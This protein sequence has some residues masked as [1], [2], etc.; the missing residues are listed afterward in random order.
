MKKL[1][2]FLLLAALVTLGSCVMESE[3][4]PGPGPEPGEKL[5]NAK[6]TLLVPGDFSDLRTRTL[7]EAQESAVEDAYV[8]IFDK[9]GSTGVLQQIV[10][11]EGITSTAN[12][13]DGV[14][15]EATFTAS[16]PRG[17]Y[18]FV[19]VANVKALMERDF[20]ASLDTRIG[21]TYNE[22]WNVGKRLVNNLTGKMFASGGAIP[23][24]GEKEITVGTVVNIEPISLYRSVARVDVGVG[25]WNGTGKTWSGNDASGKRIPFKITEIYVVRPH[26]RSMV[27]PS[28]S[29]FENGRP[30]I[31]NSARF[32]VEQSKELFK[33]SDSP[34]ITS[35]TASSYSTR[36]IYVPE[37]NTAYDH[38]NSMALVIGG[39]YNNSGTTSYYR[40]DFAIDDERIDVVRNNLY[41]FDISGVS[42]R[43]FN[44][45]ESAYEA[46][47]SNMEATL[48]EWDESPI[49]HI[50]RKGDKYLGLSHVKVEF[51]PAG[52]EELTMR[53]ITN[54][55]KF[56]LVWDG[57]DRYL[58][59]NN[60]TGFHP[61]KQ[62]GGD[63]SYV[64]RKSATPGEWLIEMTTATNNFGPGRS[65]TLHEWTVDGNDGDLTMYF[66]VIQRWTSDDPRDNAISVESSSGG[67]AIADHDTAPQ[68][69]SIKVQA[70][71]AVG[72][73]FVGWELVGTVP[74]GF[75][76]SNAQKESN[77]L[78][79]V[80]PAGNVS[81]RAKFVDPV[82]IIN[83]PT[84][85]F[86]VYF[87]GAG[88]DTRLQLGAWDNNKVKQSTLAF[89]Q[90]GSVV[91]FDL[92][93]T[94]DTWDST[95]VLFNPTDID[96]ATA[97][98]TADANGYDKIPNFSNW[99]TATGT[100]Y[101]AATHRDGGNFISTAAYHNAEYVQQGYGD[102]CK[103]VG[104]TVDQ[105]RAGVVDNGQWR[106]PTAEE[107]IFFV[108]AEN[109]ANYLDGWAPGEE[110]FYLTQSTSPNGTTSLN[111]YDATTT[112]KGI[113]GAYFPGST[114]SSLNTS[115]V[116]LPAA[117][118][119]TSSTINNVGADGYFRS[120]SVYNTSN[121]YYLNF[122]VSNVRP[123][124]M[125]SN[126]SGFPVRCVEIETYNVRMT[127]A[128][129]GGGTAIADHQE[130]G[131]GTTVKIQATPSGGM[132]FS[133]WT[134]VASVPGFDEANKLNGAT[135]NPRTFI[136]PAGRV[137]VRPNFIPAQV[138]MTMPDGYVTTW[139]G[140][141]LAAKGVFATNAGDKGANF[142][143]GKDIAYSYDDVVS[144]WPAAST[145]S[146]WLPEND[147]C[148]VGWRVP[149]GAEWEQ[150]VAVATDPKISDNRTFTLPGDQKIMLPQVSYRLQSGNLVSTDGYSRYWGS[151]VNSTYGHTFQWHITNAIQLTHDNK[152]RA[153]S[154]RCVKAA[155]P[156]EYAVAVSAADGGS[157]IADAQTAPV[158]GSVKI[159]AAP[160]LGMLF[161]GWEV[162]AGGSGTPM[163]I[164]GLDASKNPATF[165][166]PAGEVSIRAHFVPAEVEINGTIWYGAN[167]AAKGVFATSAIEYGAYFQWG[168]DVAYSYDETVSPWPDAST[169]PIN[170]LWPSESDPCPV[171]WRVPTLADWEQFIAAATDPKNV[172]NRMFTLPGDQKI[173]LPVAGY[174]DSNPQSRGTYAWFWSSTAQTNPT[175]AARFS[176]GGA[177]IDISIFGGARLN[178]G[179]VRCVKDGSGENTVTVESSDSAMGTVIAKAKTAISGAPVE[180][181]AASTAGHVFV[182][183]EVVAPVPAGF[184]LTPAQIAS[185]KMTF[186][187][188]S[189]AITLRARF[190]SDAPA[191]P[192][193]IY[194]DS[195]AKVMRVGAHSKQGGAATQQNMLFFK[196]GSTVG[197][198]MDSSADTWDAGDV[199]FNPTNID[200]ATAWAG[201]AETAEGN[202][203][204]AIPNWHS[205]L[206]ANG[207]FNPAIHS[208]DGY[209]SS[210][211]YHFAGNVRAG[212]GDP[213]KLVGLTIEQ[214]KAGNV[215]NGQWKMATVAETVATY[216]SIDVVTAVPSG[217]WSETTPG[218][219]YNTSKGTASYLPAAGR[220]NESAPNYVGVNGFWWHSKPH[221]DDVWGGRFSFS[222]S[223]SNPSNTH[224]L[225]QNG[226]A[227][228]CVGTG[229]SGLTV[230]T[231]D[232]AKGLISYG[233][234]T[235][236]ASTTGS[237]VAVG[238]SQVVEAK[239][240]A[241]YAF[242]RWVV[243]Q[244]PRDYELTDPYANPMT[245]LMPAG[246]LSLTAEFT[247]IDP[248][249]PYLLYWDPVGKVMRLGSH[250]SQGGAA[251][252]Q[253]MMFF[254]F[255]STVGFTTT[256]STDTWDE[257]DVKFDPTGSQSTYTSI[258][259]FG[260]WL[261]ANGPYN[262]ATHQ[263][264]GFI[265]LAPYHTAAN[266]AAGYGDPCR[267]VGLT[268][269]QVK[270]GTVNGNY[271]LPTVGEN[272]AFVGAQNHANV[273]DG[274]AP[275]EA[276]FSLPQSAT[277][278]GVTSLNYW[279]AENGGAWFPGSLT[280]ILN[281]AG[282]FIPAAGHRTTS[283]AT[284]N[285][286]TY[287][288][289]WS[290]SVR[291]SSNGH[292][293]N[294][295]GSN[296]YPANS[297]SYAYGF[298]VRCVE[299]QRYSYS[300][301]A[302]T[303][304][305][306]L[307]RGG[308]KVS[309]SAAEP[310]ANNQSNSDRMGTA[311][312]F[313]AVP[314]EGYMFAGWSNRPDSD[315]PLAAGFAL[316]PEQAASPTISFTMPGGNVS[317]MAL[318]VPMDEPAITPPKEPYI[319]YFE[320]TNSANTRL[321][322][323]AWD[324]NR[325]KQSTLAFFK[326]GSV[327]GVDIANASDTWDSTDV[328]FNPTATAASTWNTGD[329]AGFGAIP[330]F[331]TWLTATGATFNN[332]THR[333]DNFLSSAAY[334][335][336]A[337]LKLGY[338]DPCM[339]IG[340]TADQLKAMT[341]EQLDDVIEAAQWRL[342]TGKESIL[343][344]GGQNHPSAVGW[345][346]GGSEFRIEQ[347]TS[348]NSTSSLNTWDANGDT[349]DKGMDGVYLPG[350]TTSSLNTSGV[351]L[352]AT[353]YRNESG[354]VTSINTHGGFFTSTLLD[355]SNA[356]TLYYRQI[357]V[358]P[359]SS[360]TL[361]NTWAIR[362]V[363]KAEY[364]MTAQAT[365]TPGT[366][367]GGGGTIRIT[368]VRDNGT[369]LGT[370]V[371]SGASRVSAAGSG[372]SLQ[373]IA[374]AGY[375]FS[376]WEVVSAPAGFTL[377]E[378]Q[379]K[380]NPL[381]VVM[382][383]ANIT[384]R[385]VFKESAA[386]IRAPKAPY[387]IYF[388]GTGAN[389][390]LQLG[391]W[392]NSTVRQN[393]M[394]YFKFGSVVGF[395]MD[396]SADTWDSSDVKFNPTATS[397]S[398]WNTGDENGYGKIPNFGN[399]LTATGTTYSDA[400]HRTDNYISTA[401]YASGANA[402]NGYGDPCKLVGYTADQ[403]KGMTA[404]QLDGV[405][406]ASQWRLATSKENILFAGT[407]NHASAAGWAPGGANFSLNQSATPNGT[408]SLNY[409]DAAGD[410]SAKGIDGG[411]FPGS[412]TS[413][414]NTAGAFL[415]AAGN[416]TTSGITSTV[417]TTGYFWSSSVS[418]S[419]Y[420]H[421]L[422][423]TGSSVY[424]ATNGNYALGF[425][426]RCVS[427]TEYNMGAQVTVN[428]GST[429]NSGGTV[430]IKT[431][432]T[433]GTNLGEVTAANGTRVSTAGSG[434]S[435]KANPIVNTIFGNWEVVSAPDGFTL[436]EEQ[437]KQN[438][439]NVVMPAGSVVLRA[440]FISTTPQLQT[441]TAPYIMY[442]EGTG[443][444]TRLQ[445]GAWDN[446][447]VKQSTLAFFKFGS[448]VGFDLENSSDTWES[449][450][451]KFNPTTTPEST[452]NTASSA[453]YGA[454]PSYG[455]WFTTT[456]TTYSDATHRTDNFISN[457]S[458]YATG[459]NAKNG[460]GD[461]CRLIGFTTAQLKAMSADQIQTAINNAK[462][463]MAT[464]KENILF[465]GAHNHAN[466]LDGWAPGEANFYL[467]HISSAN[468]GT[469]ALNYWDTAA[470][471]TKGIDGGYFP[472]ST[473]ASL[474]TAGA[475]LPA[476]G[477][478]ST[479][480]A[481]NH[482]GTDGYF[483][484]SS[485]FNTSN[486]H[487][488]NFYG[489]SVYPTYNL[490]YANGFPVRCVSTTEYS[491]T[492]QATLLAPGTV[493]GG[494]KVKV[495]TAYN[496]G[497]TLDK[498]DA[499]SLIKQS[500]AGSGVSLQATPSTDHIFVGWEVA[501]GTLT[502]TEEQKTANPLNIV[503]PADNV[504]LRAV[505]QKVTGGELLYFASDGTLSLGAWDNNLVKQS[506]LAFFQ[507]GSLV[508]FTNNS[509]G[510]ASSRRLARQTTATQA[511]RATVRPRPTTPS[512]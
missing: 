157:A 498:I 259:N 469:S 8:L 408:T 77:P 79:F 245:F 36:A 303:T 359:V 455:N 445:L 339:L 282:S 58:S 344:T 358:W 254:Q 59:T 289:F 284:Y 124:T 466:V 172:G 132:I 164:A 270:S 266:V 121:G 441:P 126:T 225:P 424:P 313:K 134:V 221:T 242:S 505:F 108:G 485:V 507:F 331:T 155:P 179:S 133:H 287:G 57:A 186:T 178:A 161:A 376:N 428:P 511:S 452:W 45:V 501:S 148:P 471:A 398:T 432:A 489:T 433:N 210:P 305:D 70:S 7:T 244:G 407:H 492:A 418:S 337:N 182:A 211:E 478:R 409:W 138:T 468:N 256:G 239:P 308:G 326:S 127:P 454:I 139:A 350:S 509:D 332:A 190:A 453:G 88:A 386:Q 384:L 272:I 274:W 153:N 113:Q 459:E 156:V 237:S 458:S 330:Y 249:A 320:G 191:A 252:Q 393:T 11:A 227:V 333:T 300:A 460:Y 177:T 419:S 416:R 217:T 285:V 280:S 500:A 260:T 142:Q 115:G 299:D 40:V 9:P 405:I 387:I 449:S 238:V 318:F 16:L 4:E 26:D 470:D 64:F 37:G 105:I 482:V 490:N 365:V 14:S 286:G 220:R 35:T 119:R 510:W 431:A 97:W 467:N 224:G 219:I 307:T 236:V 222:N 279:D 55:N 422:Y 189:A 42:G 53:V 446:N 195:E 198:K 83:N 251:S 342:P 379:L 465:A 439:L 110:S 91:G 275:G 41:R 476:A 5:V 43:G 311:R 341:A 264:E 34:E 309:V 484:S 247:S 258:P 395:D 451:V 374:A 140:S 214:I 457:T 231:A 234:L 345:A 216:T 173:L 194:W 226:Y 49:E 208:V 25:V 78:N 414:L 462:W 443:A 464:A 319:L 497:T 338:G 23:M 96:P 147:P 389:T 496:N 262:A 116:F 117:G 402:K 253:S 296:V 399:W 392:D 354:A 329:A 267:L 203:Y 48:L 160:S 410:T 125:S 12:R 327:I 435:L 188:P 472:G 429:T 315:M 17:T 293:L 291:S 437:L 137:E 205:W 442:F 406:A 277:P 427:T 63:V 481:T 2:K 180:V 440:V 176:F 229:T 425:A 426:V 183:W 263:K 209:I 248:A 301:W 71:A 76:L 366:A 174:R 65:E 38:T 184:T 73:M 52:G 265:S 364:N 129:G 69:T 357:G 288:Y 340:Y 15:G 3:V 417:G 448:V 388:E 106:L 202:F 19:V 463:R 197:F 380:Q 322:L 324:N 228:R 21:E 367:S 298:A 62:P 314:D 261:T 81:L 149:T 103:L 204:G 144:P 200:P 373:A 123:A 349:S 145:D 61:S 143:W 95:D 257:T 84:S 158:G 328:R 246:A 335:T 51:S 385:A 93:N 86:L 201:A 141:N 223:I 154:V 369:S 89:F 68:G 343:L 381:N 360:G 163:T 104:L 456:G 187:M 423:L 199:R 295:D 207:P 54:L 162:L 336:G 312:T 508:G 403:I 150:F 128:Q 377:T 271:R 111:Y 413:T 383:A 82:P 317:L 421:Y 159:Q 370:S 185:P 60:A 232:A 118:Y 276:G 502:L 146:E 450:D 10:K 356:N 397:A 240:V 391:A 80:M 13:S 394:A 325:V 29:S 334:T 477:L 230:S 483:W 323:G 371:V 130:A 436:T 169:A 304:P 168:K 213:C 66:D 415:P 166:M 196:F 375:V 235:P 90:F 87:E 152:Q 348:P 368:T 28:K 486:G 434:V 1:Q 382:P 181:L 355:A 167:L 32:S 114:T 212:Y 506:T 255:G 352:P 243:T 131:A 99:L 72:N 6:M 475:F 290:S 473:T 193:I 430:T 136:M 218:G 268:V 273:L 92:E 294:F 171:G 321:Q 107:N 404:M 206:T 85:P 390:R 278:D 39:D 170:S 488:L 165:T 56:E 512:T 135:D 474:N 503:M 98:N 461:P 102:P 494:G 480:G 412:T 310:T 24:W 101:N 491:M 112:A 215:D 233:G 30:T 351:F 297:S 400:T 353:G 31:A 175:S 411:Y 487:S 499:S 27:V 495:T 283:G 269:E 281:T 33:Y 316:T 347:N 44:S 250:A 302:S 396:G 346:P 109:H 362:C 378:E 420:G 46:T 361:S 67:S 75:S 363:S 504:V 192:Y 18:N 20:G 74:T 493:Y 401:A 151:T 94:S 306:K 47:S 50:V 372:V 241:G 122:L 444:N 120:S 447:K 100:T 438:P 479:S 22:L 292:Y